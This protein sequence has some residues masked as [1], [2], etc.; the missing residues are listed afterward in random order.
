MPNMKKLKNIIEPGTMIETKHK[1]SS[2]WVLTIVLSVYENLLE[3]KHVDNYLVSVLMIGDILDCKIVQDNSIYLMT[4]EV[5]N[6][7]FL[8][9][10]IV[11]K[12]TELETIQNVRKHKRYDVYLCGYYSMKGDI[13]EN[14]CVVTNVS[15]G[16][17]SIV[18]R[19]KLNKGDILELTFFTRS[20]KFITAV[21]SV[22][23]ANERD[24]NHFYGLS[25]HEIDENSIRAFQYYIRGL[26]RKETLLHK[27]WKNQFEEFDLDS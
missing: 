3:I 4:A 17:F 24:Q 14:Y 15:L 16:G 5:Y 27:K 11:L 1:N 2:D 13:C 20:S 26:Q 6:V 21:C 8:S 18:T 22:Q 7:K 19:S 25:I 12:I 23:W 10:S 9:Q